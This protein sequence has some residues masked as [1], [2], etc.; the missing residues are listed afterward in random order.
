[1]S[2]RR[3][4]SPIALSSTTPERS[5]L[6]ARVRRSGTGPELTLRAALHR[7]GYRYRL[8]GGSGLPGT[9]DIVLRRFQVAIFV[10]GCFWHGC[11]QHGSAAKTNADFWR[12]K[13]LRNRQ[14]D[15]KVGQSL[16]SLGW[17]VLRVWEHEVRF[18][19]PKI[20]QRIQRLAKS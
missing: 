18:E 17:K 14:R 10:D 4:E 9:P 5:R 13:I 6:M 2:R 16:K 8:K 20:L 12:A 11:E 7:A 3:Q 19:L 15:M 1:M